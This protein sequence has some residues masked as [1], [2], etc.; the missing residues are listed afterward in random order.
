MGAVPARA[1][2]VTVGSGSYG[3]HLTSW[4]QRIFRETTH[5]G[6]AT[7]SKGYNVPEG[8]VK[9]ELR[10]RHRA[11]RDLFTAN[12]SVGEKALSFSHLPSPLAR[13]CRPGTVVAGYVAKGSEADPARL[14]A[15]AEALG[16]TI[17]LPHVTSKVA[18]MRFLRWQT[19]TPLEEG[20]FGL[21]QPSAD[22]DEVNPDIVL[23]PLV[24]FDTRLMRLGQG[25][26]HYDRALSMLE[27]AAA[28]GI[29]WSVQETDIL[30]TDAWD[31]PLDAVLTERSWISR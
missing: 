27:N 24:A 14:L 31:V 18:P 28:V 16:C 20:P 23:A 21:F 10:R 4:R 19:D 25:A 12:L 13:L 11:E 29:A 30:P 8:D 2:L 9:S 1:M 15:A 3:A 7:F 6:S 22:A 5:G 17:A 26:G